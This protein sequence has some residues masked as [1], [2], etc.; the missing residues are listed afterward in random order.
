MRLA[1][2]WLEGEAFEFA[3]KTFGLSEI[4]EPEFP[5]KKA[6]EDYTVWGFEKGSLGNLIIELVSTTWD[7]FELAEVQ[8]YF[9]VQS[10][11]GKIY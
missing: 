9:G 3:K 1:Y 2:P 6:S 8:K 7:L 4:I 11:R 5:D 10:E